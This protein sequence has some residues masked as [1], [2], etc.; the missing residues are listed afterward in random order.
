MAGSLSIAKTTAFACVPAKM[1][2]AFDGHCAEQLRAL[3]DPSQF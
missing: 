2:A 3:F 1:S